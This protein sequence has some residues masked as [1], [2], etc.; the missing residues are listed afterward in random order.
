MQRAAHLACKR[1]R[2]SLTTYRLKA[3]PGKRLPNLKFIL[4]V[5]ATDL[6]VVSKVLPKEVLMLL[7]LT[8]ITLTQRNLKLKGTV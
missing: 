8:A 6:F 2:G 4:V 7:S 1:K 5:A 3:P